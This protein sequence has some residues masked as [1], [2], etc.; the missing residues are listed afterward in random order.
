[1]ADEVGRSGVLARALPLVCL[2]FAVVLN[3]VPSQV[4]DVTWGEQR[5]TLALYDPAGEDLMSLRIAAAD[6][7]KTPPGG[8]KGLL[9]AAAGRTVDALEIYRWMID[10]NRPKRPKSP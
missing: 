8:A 2:W 7:R 9:Y 10:P 4:K 6:A 5:R 1:M 3:S